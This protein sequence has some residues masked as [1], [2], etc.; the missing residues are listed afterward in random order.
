MYEVIYMI[1]HGKLPD[2]ENH[3]NT[4]AQVKKNYN[5][6]VLLWHW[7]NGLKRFRRYYND[8]HIIFSLTSFFKN[9]LLR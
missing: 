3:G 6:L 1:S 8:I 2:K 7:I 4:M 5:F 9:D